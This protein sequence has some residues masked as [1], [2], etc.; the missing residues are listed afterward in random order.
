MVLIKHV[1]LQSIL[2]LHNALFQ[3]V[4]GNNVIVVVQQISIVVRQY[5]VEH[6]KS[7]DIE[8]FLQLWVVN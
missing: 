2:Q 3:Q 4:P 6:G 1:F 5:K 8:L 7:F